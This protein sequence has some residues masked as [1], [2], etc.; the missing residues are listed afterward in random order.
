MQ[1]LTESNQNKKVRKQTHIEI[2]F[3]KGK[4]MA[5]FDFWIF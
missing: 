2:Q 4:F 1:K 5:S 3:Y